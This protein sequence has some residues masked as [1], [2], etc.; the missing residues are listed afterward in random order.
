[1]SAAGRKKFAT[2]VA[3]TVAEVFCLDCVEAELRNLRPKPK[4]DAPQKKS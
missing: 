2:L 4:R 3:D 1:M